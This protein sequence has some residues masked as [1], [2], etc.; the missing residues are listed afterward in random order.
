MKSPG[1]AGA[2]PGRPNSGYPQVPLRQKRSNH[3]QLTKRKTHRKLAIIYKESKGGKKVPQRVC[4][5]VLAYYCEK[6]QLP[7]NGK[8]DI[9][10]LCHNRMCFNIDHLYREPHASNWKRMGCTGSNACKHTPAC[11]RP[12]MRCCETKQK[13]VVIKVAV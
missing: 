12:H 13:V 4:L 3:S 8:F 11:L 10:H 7:D 9:S 1:H 5:H 6:R 2:R